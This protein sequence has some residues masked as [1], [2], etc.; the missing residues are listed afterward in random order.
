MSP[1]DPKSAT[2]RPQMSPRDPKS[3]TGRPQKCHRRPQ[4][5]P[6]APKAHRVFVDLNQLH[7][8]AVAEICKRGDN[9]GT[10]G[11][12]LGSFGGHLGTFGDN[13]G[14][15]WGHP[16]RVWGH[17]GTIW[18]HFLVLSGPFGCAVGVQWVLS[19][20]S[21]WWECVSVCVSR[22]SRASW[23]C[24]GR[25]KAWWESEGVSHAC[26]GCVMDVQWAC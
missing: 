5:S 25:A 16:R 22:V 14:T 21:A 10:F 23:V 12:N 11:D 24:N 9:L 4:M 18:G 26:G 2:G 13:L 17:L 1:R 19:V 3:A 20:C 7:L 6:R 8:R 15:F